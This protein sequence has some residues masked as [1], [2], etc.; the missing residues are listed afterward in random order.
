MNE[1]NAESSAFWELRDVE[2]FLFV[3][4]NSCPWEVRL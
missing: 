3:I 1:K 2:I 4:H